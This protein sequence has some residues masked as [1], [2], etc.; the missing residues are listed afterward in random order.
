MG[1]DELKLVQETFASNWIAPLGPQV[2]KFEEE[3]A[4]LI[5]GSPLLAAA[6]PVFVPGSRSRCAQLRTRDL[7]GP[8][9]PANETE[10]KEDGGR[11]AEDRGRR[12]E[13]GKS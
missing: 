7:S 2:D 11:T 1:G 4:E 13:E 8:G 6:N 3:F 5:G 12:T 9:R 10:A